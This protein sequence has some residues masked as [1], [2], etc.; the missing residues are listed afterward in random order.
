MTST[1]YTSY[2][3]D[4]ATGVLGGVVAEWNRRHANRGAVFGSL[5]FR[6]AG[7]LETEIHNLPKAATDSALHELLTLEHS[8]HELAGRLVLQ[9]MLPKV[10]HFTN[11]CTGFTALRMP[12]AERQQASLEAMWEAIRTY[13]LRRAKSVSGNL[14]L[15]AL[16]LIT[17]EYGTYLSDQPELSIGDEEVLQSLADREAVAESSEPA[18]GDSSYDELVKLLSWAVESDALTRDE[19]SLL[20]RFDLGEQ[21]DRAALAT[22]LNVSPATLIKR[23]WRI[24][25]KLVSA[26]RTHIETFGRW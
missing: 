19:V 8:G 18:W 26:V 20:A 23:V 6:N 1:T 25:T 14:A 13:P 15:N 11:R 7:E 21:D 2:R 22:D 17:K 10:A 9:L 5:G 4:L 3:T 24:R 12:I 16:A